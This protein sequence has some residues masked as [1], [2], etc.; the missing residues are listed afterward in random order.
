M[1]TIW[2]TGDKGQLAQKIIPMLE[3]L[4][5]QSTNNEVFELYTTIQPIK[6]NATSQMKMKLNILLISISH[7][8]LLIVPH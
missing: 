5:D 1:K 2:L 3:E 6:Q 4:K 8:L 7:N